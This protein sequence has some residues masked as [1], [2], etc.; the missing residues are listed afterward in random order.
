MIS[1]LPFGFLYS[2][3]K[4]RNIVQW[5][6]TSKVLVFVFLCI[7]ASPQSLLPKMT[8]LQISP[9]IDKISFPCPVVICPMSNLFF[10]HRVLLVY[11]PYMNIKQ[12]SSIEKQ[13]FLPS[14]FAP[15]RVPSSAQQLAHVC[16][17]GDLPFHEKTVSTALQENFFCIHWH[18]KIIIRWENILQRKRSDESIGFILFFDLCRRK[19]SPRLDQRERNPRPLRFDGKKRNM[20]QN[21]NNSEFWSLEYKASKID[22]D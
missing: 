7:S 18:F 3:S 16:A 19:P 2:S 20:G 4:S 22:S 14:D 17:A 9:K 1:V 8:F 13:Y 6:A 15:T 12:V 11:F 21:Q 5:C 10:H